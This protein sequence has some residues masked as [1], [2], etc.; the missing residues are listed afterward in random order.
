MLVPD[1]V[2]S[3]DEITDLSD[4]AGEEFF[5]LFIP[6]G[7]HALYALVKVSGFMEVINGAPGASGPVLDHFNEVAVRRYLGR[8]SGT[9]EAETGPLSSHLRALFT[10]SM[11]LEG[12]NWSGDM[13]G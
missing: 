10:D 3:P 5:D 12:A 13:R 8:M 1:P 4:R 9:I 6:E 2:T 11:E 7:D